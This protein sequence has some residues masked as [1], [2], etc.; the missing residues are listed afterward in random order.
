MVK[1][2]RKQREALFRVFQRDFPN[3]ITPTKRH[4]GT[5]CP[6]CQRWS[7]EPHVTKVP[8]RQWRSFRKQAQGYWDKSG[9]V[10]IQW[11]GMWLGIETD[12]YT[13]S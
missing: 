11:R 10:M 8:S 2:T 7:S 13:H 9:C 4:G 12:G 3:W 1:T 5:Y 6:H